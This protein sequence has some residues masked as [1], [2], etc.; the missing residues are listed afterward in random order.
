MDNQT[1]SFLELCA[2][3]DLVQLA[4]D[5]RA[6][7]LWSSDGAK[8]LWSNAAGAAFFS[9]Q[10][11]ADVYAL[12]ALERS[13][14]RPHIARIAASGLTDRFSIDRLRFYRGLRV[15]LLTC[16]CKRVDL[17]NGETAALIVCSDKGLAL[18]KEPIPAF[19]HLLY[20]PGS[21]V[22]LVSEGAT[23]ETRG[24]LDGTPEIVSLPEGQKVLIGR[25]DLNGRTHD[26]GVLQ[27]PAGPQIYVLSDDPH[28][29]PVED[30]TELSADDGLVPGD[31]A[32]L[33]PALASAAIGAA[34]DTAQD[35][36]GTAAETDL[37]E[38]TDI[39]AAGE[40]DAAEAAPGPEEDVSPPD[41]TAPGSAE[42]DDTP[43]AVPDAG[44]DDA[45]AAAD[46]HLAA[47][48][49]EAVAD[50]G[51]A[52]VE[53][54]DHAA[55]PSQSLEDTG[56]ETPAGAHEDA[57]AAADEDQRGADGEDALT[58][59][60]IEEAASAGPDQTGD[61]A[62]Q[63]FVFQPRR[64]PV[65]FA[66]KMD[67][68]QRFTFLSDE[69]AE[70]LGPDATDIVGC[71]WEEVSG[72]FGLDPRGN[73]SRALDRRDT[74][75]GKTVAWPVTGAALRVPV[76]LAALPAFDRNRKFE[77]YRGFGVCRTS[78]AVQDPSGFIPMPVR[79]PE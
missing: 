35:D 50:D 23:E 2:M 57:A 7:W 43:G 54:M 1:Q 70:V 36:A 28:E 45:F 47:E 32:A 60:S 48:E 64:R 56:A 59:Q 52:A 65:R 67:V 11:V 27:I 75:S 3:N 10:S 71:T 34:S 12:T 14:A 44:A 41:D 8:I 76:D 19:A 74:W 40:V 16:Q 61:D 30:E 24:E 22:F 6:A 66:W 58:P 72:A 13:P 69:F 33:A 79:A 39:D 73:I 18:T 62:G 55:D 53:D 77:G 49:T 25:L 26:G 78:D 20:A 68:D 17:G 38:P 15:M 9:A 5:K 37:V 31:A 63:T 21:T 42:S 51:Q 29:D 4:A 46:A